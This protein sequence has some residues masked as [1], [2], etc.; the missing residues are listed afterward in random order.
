MLV[1]L[2]L[3][4]SALWSRLVAPTESSK[5]LRGADGW[6][7]LAWVGLAWV[8]WLIGAR[9]GG[10]LSTVVA[11]TQGRRVDECAGGVIS[12]PARHAWAGALHRAHAIFGHGNLPGRSGVRRWSARVRCGW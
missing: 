11:G 5:G 9:P 7:G 2:R 6:L 12:G 3:H 1:F 8:G 10:A 4:A